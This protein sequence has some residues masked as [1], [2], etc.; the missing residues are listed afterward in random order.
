MHRQTLKNYCIAL[1]LTVFAGATYAAFAGDRLA[2]PSSGAN[3][4]YSAWMIHECLLTLSPAACR[5][6][7]PCGSWPMSDIAT[8]KTLSLTDGRNVKGVWLNQPQGW[9]YT[10]GHDLLN[11]PARSVRKTKIHCY[12]SFPIGP[13]LFM[14]PLLS[15]PGR[16]KYFWNA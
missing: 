10:L 16:R 15:G 14:V 11:I 7:L 2:E 9:F 12:T 4:V 6:E 3:H 5:M 1:A 8:T 13:A